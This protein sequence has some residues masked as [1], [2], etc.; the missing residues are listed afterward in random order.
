MT[1]RRDLGY[2]DE[3]HDLADPAFYA[4]ALEPEPRVLPPA[5][6]RS[7]RFSQLEDEA[8]WTRDWICVG[9]HE[10]IAGRGD[11]LPF[12]VG[13]HGIHVQRTEGGIVA[14]FNKAQHG[15]CRAVPLQCQTGAKTKC[16]FTSCGYSRDRGAIPAS[17]LG[18]GTPQMH[19]YLGLRP[20]RLLTAHVQSWGPLI[21]VNLDVAP[22]WPAEELASL[23]RLGGFFGNHKP[24]WSD[25]VW[26]E[27]AANWKLMGQAL[28][29][30]T[31][32]HAR[33]DVWMLAD[34]ALSDGTP[35]RAAWL[36]PNLVL[37]AT[38][39]STAIVNLQPTAMGQTLCRLSTY[40]SDPRGDRLFWREEIRLRAERGEAENEAR[41]LWGTQ[42]H[43][44]TIGA[45]LPNQPD[46]PGAWMQGAL[47][48]R[49]ARM[50]RGDFAQ[51]LY[52]NPRG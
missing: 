17:E 28:A 6:F 52:Q 49:V 23:G 48:A 11:L 38:E 34:T 4:D 13:T 12:T 43:P 16:S 25:E 46:A 35:A 2:R 31:P 5:A 7:L 14:R 18:D 50:P 45:A 10:A 51:P 47:A 30:G 26:L 39:R 9:T 44:H 24:A 36:F 21:F 22:A 41:A 27:Y 20:E 40:G 3:G 8:V 19:Q 29:S 1:H 42:H 32:A 37:L 33:S 15:G